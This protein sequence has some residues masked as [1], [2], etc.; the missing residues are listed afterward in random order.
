LY[1]EGLSDGVLQWDEGTE[2]VLTEHTGRLARLA[3]DIDDVS[4]AEEGRLELDPVPVAVGHLLA[5]AVESHQ[6]AFARAGVRLRDERG[7]AD[8]VLVH[9]DVHRVRQVLDNLLRNALRHTPPE[10]TV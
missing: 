2:R 8:D 7:S 1:C 6:D 4:R 10:G 5:S 9:V 3:G